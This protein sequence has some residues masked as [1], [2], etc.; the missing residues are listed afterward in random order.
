MYSF[1]SWSIEWPESFVPVSSSSATSVEVERRILLYNGIHILNNDFNV[2]FGRLLI[3]FL[4][5]AL[6][7]LCILSFYGSVRLY[8]NMDPILYTFIVL[9]LSISVVFLVPTAMV[10]STMFDMST[11]L[12]H[13]LSP[14]IKRIPDK[15]TRQ[16]CE[17]NLKSCA[18]IRVQVGNFYHMEAKAKLTLMVHLVN[19]IVFLMVNLKWYSWRSC[20][21]IIINKQKLSK[22]QNTQTDKI[23]L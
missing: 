20:R 8:H 18:V 13:Q 6:I 22:G 7:V 9:V 16:I 5:I 11:Q 19:G 2:A 12:P 21:E 23:I 17:A 15:T 14:K 4:K 3:P 10:M 1:D